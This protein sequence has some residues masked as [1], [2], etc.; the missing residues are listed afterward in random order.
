MGEPRGPGDVPEELT[1]IDVGCGFDTDGDGRPDT[2]LEPDGVD[3][4]VAVD[5][6][7]DRFADQVLRIGPD[8]VVRRV[9]P[10][11]APADDPL[12]DPLDGAVGG[13]G[14]Q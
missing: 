9:G 10:P 1:R 2:V 14:D 6:D 5:L 4:V 3:L 8:A 13:A 11:Q 12:D 7:G